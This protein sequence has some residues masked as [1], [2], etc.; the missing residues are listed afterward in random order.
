[1]VPICSIAATLTLTAWIR[2]YDHGENIREQLGNVLGRADDEPHLLA[3][4]C[5]QARSA[6]GVCSLRGG[7]FLAQFTKPLPDVR[8]GQGIH[9]G[10]IELGHDR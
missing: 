10:G 8:I 2:F 4:D 5:W 9:Q 6:S 3:W 1:M 7:N